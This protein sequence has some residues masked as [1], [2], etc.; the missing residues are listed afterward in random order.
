MTKAFDSAVA[1]QIQG[2]LHARQSRLKDQLNTVSAFPKVL[3]QALP[4]YRAL[5][6]M[7]SAIP[8][9]MGDEGYL[10]VDDMG[11]RGRKEFETVQNMLDGMIVSIVVYVERAWSISFGF[12]GDADEDPDDY[13]LDNKFWEACPKF[14]ELSGVD[15]GWPQYAD[16]WRTHASRESAARRG[17]ALIDNWKR[18]RIKARQAVNRY[19]QWWNAFWKA[20]P[21]LAAEYEKRE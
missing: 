3:R 1:K 17:K 15:G 16:A 14:Y 12:P 5:C 10:V 20:H 11:K 7:S 18:D 8:C 2:Q 21:E 4:V 9:T 19:T 6:D 13:R